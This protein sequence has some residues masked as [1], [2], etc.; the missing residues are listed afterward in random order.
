MK[1]KKESPYPPTAAC[2]LSRKRN[3]GKSKLKSRKESI[4]DMGKGESVE[5]HSPGRQIGLCQ[6]QRPGPLDHRDIWKGVKC[7]KPGMGMSQGG[8]GWKCTA[9]HFLFDPEGNRELLTGHL[10][11]CSTVT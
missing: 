9:E 4:P 8:N 2:K 3:Q 10:Y 5:M 1:G 11:G 6:V 7:R